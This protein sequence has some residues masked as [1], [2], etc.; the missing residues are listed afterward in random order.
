MLLIYSLTSFGRFIEKLQT[1]QHTIFIIMN[2]GKR[3]QI[4]FSLCQNFLLHY[5]RKKTFSKSNYVKNSW[6]IST[7]LNWKFPITIIT[8]FSFKTMSFQSVWQITISC[9]ILKTN[10]AQIKSKRLSLLWKNYSKFKLTYWIIQSLNKKF[11]FTELI[12]GL[13]FFFKTK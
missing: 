9:F 13:I 4:C 1:F 7:I 11:M 5:Q 3:Q 8:L 10:F 6:N 2:Y 12:F